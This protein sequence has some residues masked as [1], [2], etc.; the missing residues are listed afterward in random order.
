MNQTVAIT[1]AAVTIDSQA[2]AL[3]AEATI[4]DND[5]DGYVETLTM[6]FDERLQPYKL[7]DLSIWNITDMATGK[8]LTATN[9]ELSDDYLQVTV[10]FTGC[11]KGTTTGA[12]KLGVNYNDKT[13]LLD[14]AGN[15]VD[16]RMRRP[17][18][19]PTGDTVAPIISILESS[20][21]PM[22]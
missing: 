4:V 19:H 2:P 9:A 3:V 8:P 14:W 10:T 18:T 11:D 17:A 15:P 12:M 20:T 21:A 13:G 16:F 5:G 6:V 22:I 1:T 7:D